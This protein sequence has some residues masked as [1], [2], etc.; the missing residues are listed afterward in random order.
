M[1]HKRERA[2]VPSFCGRG[3]L[4]RPDA[5]VLKRSGPEGL[6]KGRRRPWPVIA[7]PVKLAIL[8]MLLLAYGQTAS[9]SSLERSSTALAGTVARG[10]MHATL[11]NP[12]AFSAAPSGLTAPGRKVAITG[13]QRCPAHTYFVGQTSVVVHRC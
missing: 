10:D 8:A 12:T 7:G 11:F 1:L 13:Q 6:R 3:P 2:S 4:T 5:I 9:W